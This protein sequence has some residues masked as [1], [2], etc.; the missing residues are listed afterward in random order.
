M[1]SLLHAPL[2]SVSSSLLTAT[3]RISTVRAADTSLNAR[4][5]LHICRLPGFI[6][7]VPPPALDKIANISYSIA[8][9][10]S[11]MGLGNNLKPSQAI[12]QEENH[13]LLLPAYRIPCTPQQSD[14]FLKKGRAERYTKQ[15]PE[16]HCCHKAFEDYRKSFQIGVNF[17]WMATRGNAEVR[18]DNR[19][20]RFGGTPCSLTAVAFCHYAHPRASCAD[21]C[22]A[23][24][25]TA[26]ICIC[27]ARIV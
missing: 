12:S 25:V 6:G 7:L 26:L 15:V 27:P 16:G 19:I 10:L 4:T 5:A 20:R 2:S 1:H 17:G 18:T 3:A 11:R 23:L 21:N 14:F 13:L 8:V 24:G 22:R 9:P